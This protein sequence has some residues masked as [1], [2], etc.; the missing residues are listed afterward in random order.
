M[1]FIFYFL[2]IIFIY[3]FWAVLGLCHHVSFSLVAGKPGL[4]FVAV[5]GLL[6][7]LAAL[8]EVYGL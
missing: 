7:A 3:L 4:L 2:L 1:C 8:A 6:A 5:H